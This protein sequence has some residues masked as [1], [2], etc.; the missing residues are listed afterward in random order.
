MATRD[1]DRGSRGSV[2]VEA[3]EHLLEPYV[4]R[5]VCECSVPLDVSPIGECM[6]CRRPVIGPERIAELA[7]KGLIS[8][9]HD[10]VT[11]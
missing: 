9:K 2:T 8:T 6:G 7:A 11:P 10:P 3:R 1:Y 5:W 4:E